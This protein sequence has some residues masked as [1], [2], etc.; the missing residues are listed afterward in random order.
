MSRTARTRSSLALFLVVI[1][2][3]TAWLVGRGVARA[4]ETPGRSEVKDTVVAEASAAEAKAA[5]SAR[6]AVFPVPMDFKVKLLRAGLDARALCAAGVASNSVL[7]TLQAAADSMNGAPT[8]LA[9]A[10]T[11]YATARNTA[12]SLLRTIQSGKATQE[13]LANYASAQSALQSAE[14]ARQSVLDAYFNAA[15]ANLPNAQRL[16]LGNI[17]AN[18][19]WGFPSE[20]LVVSRSE[21]QWVALRDALSNE[22]IAVELPDTL[23]P[24][25]QELL[26][27]VRADQ[28]V[29]AARTNVQGNLTSVTLSWNTAAGD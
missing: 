27:T 22:R 13:E 7:A 3:V 2:S 4:G 9:S 12:D 8:A 17:R 25:A 26:A 20:Y 1:L 28:S 11:T 15:I 10:D 29:A 23:S 19:S 5:T 24:S 16:A 6:T 18:S 21:A 14:S